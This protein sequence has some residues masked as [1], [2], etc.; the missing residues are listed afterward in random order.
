MSEYQLYN[1][2]LENL[3][4]AYIRSINYRV[5]PYDELLSISQTPGGIT[6]SCLDSSNSNNLDIFSHV[7]GVRPKMGIIQ[8]GASVDKC[9]TCGHNGINCKGH[10][11][12]I[13]LKSENFKYYIY[14]PIFF[15]Y[16]VK[17]LQC[18]CHVC[19]KIL[20]S[21]SEKRLVTETKGNLKIAKIKELVEKSM[22]DH[23][24][25]TAVTFTD[26]DNTYT[27]SIITDIDKES[28]KM[29]EIIQKISQ[30]ETLV[31][32]PEEVYAILHKIP[33][34][35]LVLFGFTRNFGNATHP[36][37][38]ILRAIPVIPPL[39]RPVKEIPGQGFK[40]H[41]I[42]D[43]YEKLISKLKSSN[44]NEFS[45]MKKRK[46]IQNL[47]LDF[48][49]PK[50]PGK[51]SKTSKN[52]VELIQGRDGM[53]REE[54][55]GKRVHFNARTVVTG[56]AGLM[57]GQIGVPKFIA[58]TLTL[59]VEVT[60]NNK[61]F[62]DKLFAEGKIKTHIPK[63]DKVYAG[64]YVIVKPENYPFVELMIGDH[65]ERT[66]LDGDLVLFNRQPTLH[67]KGFMAARVVIHNDKVIKIPLQYTTPLNA[68]FDGDEMNLHFPQTSE[69]IYEA[70]KL[71]YVSNNM[72][73][74]QTSR[75]EFGQ[76]LD[77]VSGSFKMTLNKDS[78][79]SKRISGNCFNRIFNRLY[80]TVPYNRE[81]TDIIRRRLELDA[82]RDLLCKYNLV[83]SKR[84]PKVF[85]N[86]I[87][88]SDDFVVDGKA[89]FSLALKNDFYHVI[90]G[91]K[92]SLRIKEGVMVEGVLNKS[93]L[94]PSHDSILITIIKNYGNIAA[95]DFITDTNYIVNL[96]LEHYPIHL[97]IED[98]LDNA[99]K[100]ELFKNMY[101]STQIELK[102]FDQFLT[103]IQSI[104]DDDTFIEINDLKEILKYGASKTVYP[105]NEMFN[106]LLKDYIVKRDNE[107][108]HITTPDKEELEAKIKDLTINLEFKEIMVR[109][110]GLDNLDQINP[111]SLLGR[112][113]NLEFIIKR[114]IFETKV[115]TQN[116]ILAG[117]DEISRKFYENNIQTIT[118]S[119]NQFTSTIT[120]YFVDVD[121]NFQIM[122]KSG[123]KG[124]DASFINIAGII[125]QQNFK[126]ER[127]KG[128]MFG[129][130]AH[131]GDLPGD[132]GIVEKGFCESNYLSGALPR[133]LFNI[134]KASREGNLDTAIGVPA[135][136]YTQ[137]RLTKT[138]EDVRVDC[139]NRRVNGIDKIG[140]YTVTN[141]SGMIIST[142][143][144]CDS[145]DN[146]KMKK[147]RLGRADILGSVDVENIFNRLNNQY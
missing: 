10:I 37:N 107:G 1:D 137:R 121:N 17:I 55:M 103:D 140:N 21:D 73:S 43:F 51:G 131:P 23:P 101:K 130:R 86:R 144:S 141:S 2:S 138:C 85:L 30:E 111:K 127:L 19:G 70:E 34:E 134:V 113:Q 13:E 24:E 94:G 98:C 14:H 35:D 118:Q 26:G 132:F 83:K 42:S 28:L 38:F 61:D 81:P 115:N 90:S 87:P 4:E 52:I 128:D 82:K 11:G 126:A 54:M 64:K 36:E 109:Y 75:A 120:K 50:K 67:K 44:E 122:I 135:N 93:A 65:V 62:L 15:D 136:G 57:F 133:E 74:D 60:I 80:D 48:L 123:A 59:K 112:M 69:A 49:S 125:G 58:D 78:D 105:D 22:Y 145:F 124:N 116:V 76:V 97:G 32:K 46:D 12:H 91:E 114:K 108:I 47:V 16:V 68:D 77:T 117:D 18:I 63:D 9:G 104:V 89:L 53:G 31:Y 95:E 96:Y 79:F 72:I 3:E 88:D 33:E 7:L 110:T 8:R 129:K 84:D 102:S 92:H 71:M 142:S 119:L 40:L 99:S 20:L 139:L 147:I 25:H 143:Y 106:Y 5:I 66:M 100:P 6:G 41:E 39:M 27:K 29:Y 45:M 56:D 146:T